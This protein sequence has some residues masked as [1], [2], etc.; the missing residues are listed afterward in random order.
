MKVLRVLLLASAV[1]MGAITGAAAQQPVAPSPESLA[2]AK[3]LFSVISGDMLKDLTN[4]MTSQVWPTMEAALKSRYPQLDAAT[5]AEARAEFERLMV[6]DMT[7]YMES[8][9]AIYA[10]YLT[11]DEMKEILAFHRTPTGAKTLRIMPQIMGE[12]MQ[13]MAPRMQ[14]SMQRINVA[15]TGILKKHGYEN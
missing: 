15:L 12:L 1:G 4:K 13:N 3:E 14:N 10:R 11:V 7:E 5:S 6:A 9:P 8:A 2:V